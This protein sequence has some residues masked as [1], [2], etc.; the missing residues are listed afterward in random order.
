[1]IWPSHVDVGISQADNTNMC[2]MVGGHACLHV[3]L[4]N[5]TA[6]QIALPE[7]LVEN[8]HGGFCHRHLRLLLH[9][10]VHDGGHR[11]GLCAI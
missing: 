10:K 4:N 8:V 2:R 5:L 11:D 7:H 6:G 3:S 1:M 9:G